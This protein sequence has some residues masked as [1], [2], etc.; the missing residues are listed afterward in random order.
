M[1]N[2]APRPVHVSASS[3]RALTQCTMAFYYSRILRLPEKEWPRTVVGSLLHSI[4]ECL[5]HPRHRHHFDAITLGGTKVDYTLSPALARLVRAWQVKHAIA[6]DLIA[7]LDGMLHVCLNLLDFHWKKADLDLLTKQPLTYG[8]EHEFTLDLGAG[9]IIRG[10]IDD[11]AQVD[12]IMVIRDFKSA[13][14]KPTAAEVPHTVQAIV[15]QLYVWQK[16][17]MPARVE[18]VYVRHPPTPRS[19]QRHLQIVQPASA[20]HL[21]GFS[22]YVRSI[23]AQVSQFGLEDAYSAPCDDWGFCKN[24]CTHYAPHPYWHVARGDDPLGVAPLSSHLTVEG[25]T[26]AAAKEK[27]AL[28]L[29]R[30]H[31]GCPHRWTGE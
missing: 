19:P 1:S 8:P 6:A 4:C 29:E 22:D 9:V 11:M 13:K 5:R 26:V 3:L 23:H 17:K 7:D 12:G 21:D 27:G 16:F 10:Y 28:V 2:P 30:K 18:F 31:A 25:A 24:V 14:N 20:M 15:Y